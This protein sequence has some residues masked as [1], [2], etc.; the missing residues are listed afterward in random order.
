MNRIECMEYTLIIDI[1]T[2]PQKMEVM[3]KT[4]FRLI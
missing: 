4:H 2:I 1:F 3:I